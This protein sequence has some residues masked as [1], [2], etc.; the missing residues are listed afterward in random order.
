M[1][2]FM[3]AVERFNDEVLGE[4]PIENPPGKR[5]KNVWVCTEK[6]LIYLNTKPSKF[7]SERDPTF[8]IIKPK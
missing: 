8:M 2:D 3:V 1:I 6:H 7:L 4:K 5:Q